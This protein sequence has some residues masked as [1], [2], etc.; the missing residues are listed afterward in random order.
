MRYGLPSSLNAVTIGENAQRRNSL[1]LKERQTLSVSTSNTAA[2]P[3][4]TQYLLTLSF[5]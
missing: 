2:P 4:I 5:Q 3:S 1:L